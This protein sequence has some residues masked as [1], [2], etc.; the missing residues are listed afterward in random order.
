MQ[1]KPFVIEF[2]E[3]QCPDMSDGQTPLEFS[4]TSRWK[5]S[6]IPEETL[7]KEILSRLDTIIEILQN[8][9]GKG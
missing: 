9:N 6:E 4:R 5:D 3:N 2:D 1:L 8:Q 7:N